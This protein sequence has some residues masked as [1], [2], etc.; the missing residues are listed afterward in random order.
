MLRLPGSWREVESGWAHPG[1]SRQFSP[2]YAS[3][4]TAR[5][6]SITRESSRSAEGSEGLDLG[7]SRLGSAPGAMSGYGRGGELAM[8]EVV[9][10]VNSRSERDGRGRDSEEAR[11]QPPLSPSAVSFRRFGLLR[12]FLR[13]DDR[14]YGTF[15]LVIKRHFLSPRQ[16]AVA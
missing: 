4:V 16:E 14:S 7:V 13:M 5:N 12:R 2:P 1:P 11:R 9:V 15:L 3:R 6:S 10:A 8:N